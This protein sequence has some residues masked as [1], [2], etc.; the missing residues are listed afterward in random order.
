MA[1]RAAQPL[2]SKQH[3]IE[4]PTDLG[5]NATKDIASALNAL[6]ADAFT[7]FV[8]TK[9][10]HWHVSGPHFRDYHLLFD[11]QA[12]EILAMTDEIAERVRKLGGYTLRSIGDIARHQRLKD[13]DA[14]YVGPLDML[15]ELCEDNQRFIASMRQAHHVCNEHKD[16]ASTSLIENYIDQAEK[17][18]WFLYE[19]SRGG[20]SAAQ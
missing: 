18:A 14:H 4:T 3:R 12:T 20:G 5:P 6:L 9:N 13:N 1:A 8:K 16:V 19:A 15:T 2:K 10:F 11:D 7:L 17:R